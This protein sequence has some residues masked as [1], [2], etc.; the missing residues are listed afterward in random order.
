[1]AL[2]ASLTI[3]SSL[4]HL[5]LVD[6]VMN[7]LLFIIISR[8]RKTPRVS[9]S[10]GRRM[11]CSLFLFGIFS[12]PASSHLHIHLETLLGFQAISIV[13]LN[14]EKDLS[15]LLIA[16]V[17]CHPSNCVSSKLAAVPLLIHSVPLF[18]RWQVRSSCYKVG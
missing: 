8:T 4:S 17:L 3:V 15:L 6:K 1:M 5:S 10:F 14:K 7:F 9:T 11:G 13:I 12:P 18:S 2:I 16:I